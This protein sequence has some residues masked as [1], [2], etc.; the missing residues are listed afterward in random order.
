VTVSICGHSGVLVAAALTVAGASDPLTAPIDVPEALARELPK[1]LDSAAVPGLQVAWIEDGKLAWDAAFGRRD[2]RNETTVGSDTVFQ[3]ASLTKQVVAY[4]VL[5]MFDRA[6]IELDVPLSDYLPYPDIEHDER[7]HEITARH[8]LSHSTGFPNWRNDGPLRIEF[9]PGERFQYSGEG[10]MYLQYVIEKLSGLPLAE[11]VAREVFEPFAM[12]RSSLVWRP[13]YDADFACGHDAHGLPS[14]KRKPASG[15]AAGTLHTTA[16]EYARFMLAL[17]N[18]EGLASETALELLS[19]QVRVTEAVYWGLGVGLQDMSDGR[20][21]W[22]WGDDG[23]FRAFML[24]DP[25]AGR[26]LVYFTNSRHGLSIG[27]AVVQLAFGASGPAFDYLDYERFDSPARTLR[28]ELA[29]VFLEH[30][31]EPGVTRHR[32]LLASHR[33]SVVGQEFLNDVGYACL[34]AGDTSAALA[35]FQRNVELHPGS[36]I[37]HDSLGEAYARAGDKP[38]A[39]ASYEHSLE[40]NP[41]NDN[42]SEQLARLR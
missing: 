16:R 24:G 22:Q 5:R 36:W 3:A 26:G 33:Q 19:P 13:D 35:A 29:R 1:L 40:L 42:A 18:G 20:T 7:Y 11:L 41:E 32:E 14:A 39:I 25:A 4:T 31:A 6:E 8:V 10:F 38:R 27:P 12:K 17:M 9:A 37:V 30:G 34:A 2:L 21:F 28:R 15:H 23:D